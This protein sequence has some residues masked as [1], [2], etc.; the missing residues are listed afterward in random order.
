MEEEE[1]YNAEWS[2]GSAPREKGEIVRSKD[3][4][5]GY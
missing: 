4:G 2:G 1:E 3:V 5:S